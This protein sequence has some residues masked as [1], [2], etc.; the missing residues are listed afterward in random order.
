MSRRILVIESDVHER[1]ILIEALTDFD[2]IAVSDAEQALAVAHNDADIGAVV[3][4]MTLDGHSGLEFLYEF[5][6]YTDW[7]HIPVF[8]YSSVMVGDEVLSARS[9]QHLGV[10]NYFYRPQSS[11]HDL[12]LGIEKLIGAAV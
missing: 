11:L 10:A 3:M 7:L 5:R 12:R 4:D 9:W 2:V 6:S 8:V 1:S